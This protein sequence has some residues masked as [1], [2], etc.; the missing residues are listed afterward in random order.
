MLNPFR[1][2]SN[3][4]EVWAWGMYDLA[5][6]SF[7]LLI[8]TLFFG[9][10]FKD[11]VT[12]GNPGRG[13][14]LF[15]L[16]FAVA[17]LV[18]VLTSPLLGAMAD[19]SGR[20]KTGLMVMGVGCALATAALALVGPGDIALAFW[21]YALANV[22]F[23]GGENFLAAFLPEIST[24]DT[25]GRVSAIGWTMGYVGG[26]LC[27]PLALLIPGALGRSQPTPEWF[28]WVF[29]FAGAWFFLNAIPTLLFLRE[30]KRPETLPPGA[31]IATVGFTRLAVTIRQA[32]RYRQLGRFLLVFLIYSCG[33]QVIIVFSGII[34]NQYLKSG[35]ELVGFA[36]VLA[37]VAGVGSFGLGA[38]QDRIGHKRS[39]VIALA[40]WIVTAL[41]AAALPSGGGA[42]MWHF[43]LVGLGVGLGLGMAG[44]ASRTLVGAMTPTHKTAEFF[45]LWGLAYKLAG[46][47]GPPIY[48]WISATG[49]Q[50]PAMLAV[51]ATFI[52]GLIGVAFIRPE[53]GRRVAEDEDRR[54]AATLPSPVGTGVQPARPS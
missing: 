4:R 26:L 8:N 47:M 33:M 35:K 17:S 52:A 53:E 11:F 34:A 10:Y 54:L 1:G 20:K 39:L 9:I 5:N 48:V 6:Q 28:R 12:V 40:V 24:R 23:M 19:F 21:V 29:L 45:G 27:L 50:Q 38:F 18:V 2:L 30:R 37:A 13:V 36:W 44:T 7:T 32:G 51:A 46:A 41:G 16:A 3:P 49:G 31:T 43:S 14:Y 22:F 42:P 15:G 25:M